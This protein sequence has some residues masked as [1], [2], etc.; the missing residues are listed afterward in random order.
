V[1]SCQAEATVRRAEVEAG[2]LGEGKPGDA[3]SYDATFRLNILGSESGYTFCGL[4][5]DGNAYFSIGVG[6]NTRPRAI[7]APTRTSNG[8]TYQGDF[9][10]LFLDLTFG[11]NEFVLEG[12]WGPHHLQ[13]QRRDATARQCLRADQ[14]CRQRCFYGHIG[15]RIGW[16]M[17]IFSFE[18]YSSNPNNVTTTQLNFLGAPSVNG[19]APVYGNQWSGTLQFQWAI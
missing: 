19:T 7:R 16:F 1:T 6:A 5:Y 14:Q 9:A 3:L 15:V 4:C 8:A 10:D 12:G 11:D 18:N 13:R 2:Q 17:P